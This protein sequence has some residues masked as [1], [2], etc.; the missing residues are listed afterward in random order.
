MLMASRG[1]RMTLLV[2]RRAGEGN[3]TDTAGRQARRAAGKD[4]TAGFG[5][6]TR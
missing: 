4:E 1:R 2:L 3:V 5:Q 6:G